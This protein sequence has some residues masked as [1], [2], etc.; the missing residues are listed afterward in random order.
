MDFLCELIFEIV[1]E[2]IFGVTVKNP[3]LKTWTKTVFFILFS[4]AIALWIL[5]SGISAL[6]RGNTDGGI[7]IVIMGIGL[8][9]AFAIGTVYGHRKEWKQE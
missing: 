7:A 4:Q 5:Y 3:K 6:Q 9:V 8:I 2:G 1:L